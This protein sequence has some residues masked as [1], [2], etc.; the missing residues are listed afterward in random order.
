MDERWLAA[1]LDESG[2]LGGE[3]VR[4]IEVLDTGAFNSQT[5]RLRVTLAGSTPPLALVLKQ[6]TSAQWSIEAAAEEAG[7]YRNVAR[8]ADHPPVVPRCLAVGSED[9]PFVLLEDLSATHRPPL[10]RDEI[11]STSGVMPSPTDQLAVIDTLARLQAFWWE[12]PLQRTGA[13]TFNYWSDDGEGFAHYAK[14]RRAS[15]QTVREQ[16]HDR[17]PTRVIDLYEQTFDGLGTHWERW[18]R[19]RVE[20]RHQLTLLHGDAYFANFLCPLP[21]QSGHA[22]LLDWQ[23][24]CIDI[25]AG[26]LVNL[27]ATFWNR[28]DRR[29]GDRERRLLRAFHERLLHHGVDGY[30]FDDLLHDYRL[31]LVYWL[32][33]P[34]QDA[35]DGS[36]PDYWWPKMQCLID[37][38]ED[39]Q[40]AELL[41]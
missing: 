32:L 38:Y 39:W 9:A 41:Q 16:H 26:D 3:T 23:S 27:I 35:R 21:G 40:C 15:W 36:R 2:V 28:A 11:V 18:L 4:E 14:R 34:V 6:P 13:V 25:G 29:E 33:V 31:G 24:T 17:L 10:T 37:A 5:V 8:L 19:P 12:H 30:A 1:L 22:Y 7:F 20:D